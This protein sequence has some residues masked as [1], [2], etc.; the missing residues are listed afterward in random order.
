MNSRGFRKYLIRKALLTITLFLFVKVFFGTVF[1]CKGALAMNFDLDAYRWKN[2][3][4]IIFVPPVD[5]ENYEAQ[6]EILR[7]QSAGI[8]DRDLRIVEVLEKESNADLDISLTGESAQEMRNRLGVTGQEFQVILIGKDGT[9]KLRSKAA[10]SASALFQL[11]DAM[12]MRQEE[13]REKKKNR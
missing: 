8:L 10:V 12:P 7:N 5:S 9:V 3:I 13:M 6:K 2:R 4:L 1:L 11:I